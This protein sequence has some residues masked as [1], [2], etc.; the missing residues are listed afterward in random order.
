VKQASPCHASL[1]L[2]ECY[3]RPVLFLMAFSSQWDPSAVHTVT[4]ST[5]QI[6]LHRSKCKTCQVLRYWIH[7]KMMWLWLDLMIIQVSIIHPWQIGFNE[8]SHKIKNC[9]RSVG[10]LSV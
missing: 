1:Y 10:L 5:F 4:T 9:A 2:F 6:F 3:D 7:A 8:E